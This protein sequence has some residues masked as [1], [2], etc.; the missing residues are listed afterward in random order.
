LGS[1]PL[2]MLSGFIR[3]KFRNGQMEQLDKAYKDSA[4]ITMESLN[5]IRTVVSFG[6]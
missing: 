4:Q 1:L 6:V 5:N 3:S 2:V